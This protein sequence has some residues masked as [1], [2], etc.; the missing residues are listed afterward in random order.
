MKVALLALVAACSFKTHEV[1]S[2][3]AMGDAAAP[4]IDAPSCDFSSQTDTC[5]LGNPN[6]DLTLSGSNTYDTDTGLLNGVAAPHMR[7]T[8]REGP[9][10]AII[11]RNFH[12]TLGA[13]LRA[14]GSLPLGVIAIGSINLDATTLIDVGVGGA[15]ARTTCDNGAVAGADDSGG[16]AGGGGGGFGATGGHGGSGDSDGTVS[17]GGAGGSAASP[18]PMGPLGGCPGAH[19]GMGD[20]AGGAGGTAGGALYL[21]AKLQ[22]VMASSAG[23]QAGAGGGGPGLVGSGTFDNGD[24]GGGGGGAGGMIFL[25]SP[26]VH[27]LG[28]LAANGGGGGEASGN[29][30]AGNPGEDAILGTA[31]AGG[32]HGG[33]STGT[34]GGNGGA[35]TGAAQSVTTINSG[36]GGGGGGA[37]GIIYIRAADKQVGTV[38]PP[39]S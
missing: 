1:A 21:A 19:G 26:S 2:S 20:V 25:E 8:G 34:D 39:A 31:A 18:A 9:F 4:G 14:T 33:S 29:G 17:A 22:I 27:A 30:E 11:V 7:I 6:N 13:T 16:A 38:S 15:G 36:G 37:V 3:D 5:A 28:V 23:I 35:G 10:D 24:T 32:G 12:M